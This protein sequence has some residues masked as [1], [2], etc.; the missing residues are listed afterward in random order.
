MRRH[1]RAELLKQ[2]STRST[3]GL[4]AAMVALVL[5]VVVLHGLGLPTEN[6]AKRS[7]QL[8]VVFGWA[9]VLG[10]LFACLV[11]VLS[12]TAEFRYGTIRPTLIATP[13]RQRVLSA[14]ALAGALTGGVLGLLAA[15]VA[16][17]AGSV[18]LAVRGVGLRLGA[19]DYAW[20]LGGGAGTAALWATIGVGVG[21]LVRNQVPAVAGVCAW[22]L[23]IETVLLGDI[24]IVGDVGRF[25]PGA[26][27]RA[28]T[29]QDPRLAPALAVLLL[30]LYAA[31]AS[32]AATI[33]TLRRDVA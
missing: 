33:A 3:L 31:V 17:A 5:F 14:K 22:L 1:V 8:K 4:L 24:D 10:A 26:L 16:V 6:V 15:A 18:A 29:G 2:R 11:G 13:E 25:T 23:F 32:A 30:A 9:E 27:G 20:L 21:A 7:D 12:I 28:A 19:A